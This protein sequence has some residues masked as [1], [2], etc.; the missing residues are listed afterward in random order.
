M[1]PRAE[2]GGVALPGGVGCS[3]GYNLRRHGDVMANSGLVPGLSEITP[4]VMSEAR[5]LA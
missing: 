4:N 3:L 5:H 2:S 1:R